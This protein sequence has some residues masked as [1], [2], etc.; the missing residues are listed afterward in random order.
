MNAFQQAIALLDGPTR[1]RLPILMASFALVALLEVFSIGLIFPLMIAL[2]NP[3]GLTD[4]PIFGWLDVYM[5]QF[6]RA[7]LIIWLGL[8][9][10]AG[11]VIKN[12]LAVL[13]VRWQYR[14]I[15]NAEA[16]AG[17]RLYARYLTAPWPVVAGRNTSELIRNASNSVSHAFLSVIIPGIT[18][19]SELT[20]AIL[21]IAMLLAL[22]P[23]IAAA[24]LAF[25]L[26][27]GSVYYLG[28][29]NRL[30]QIGHEFQ[31]ANFGLLNHLKQGLGA[32][33]EIRVLSRSDEFL[34]QLHDVRRAYAQSQARRSFLQVLP[35]YYFETMLVFA[36][37]AIVAAMTLTRGAEA[38]PPILA[39]FA[40]ATLRLLASAGRILTLIQQ[41]RIGL[42]PLAAISHDMQHLRPAD[43]RASTPVGGRTDRS[44]GAPGGIVLT[45]VTFS[46]GSDRPA[47]ADLS[48]TI[49]WGESLGILGPSG[50]GKSTLI[51][52]ILGLIVPDAGRIEID[53]HDMTS[54]LPSWQRRVGYVPQ[55][56]YLTDDT[57]RR[58]VAFGLADDVIDND[59]LRRALR[60]ANLD[61]FV[62]SLPRG[63]DTPV[64]E[65][66]AFL[67][68]GQRQRIGIAR[69]LYHD[70]SVLVLDEATSALDSETEAVVLSAVEALAGQKTVI[71]VA[72]RL[73]TV[74]RCD[75]LLM[76][77]QGKVADIGGFEELMQRNETFVRMIDLNRLTPDAIEAAEL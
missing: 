54:I 53:S 18:L 70:P 38:V 73:S 39:L 61:G 22:D 34:R 74:R 10:G 55:T 36:V 30:A 50:S 7:Q 11:F 17:E 72:H 24:T 28:V 4:M 59:A 37:I 8:L 65:L 25:S 63:A 12:A 31:D 9:I 13:L 32:G 77:S 51:D 46:Y 27:A 15:F 75:R 23:A 48:L 33:R 20:L 49:H 76:L 35:R 2:V 19:A 47:I 6:D 43:P 40:V 58:N 26:A 69:A 16:S 64:G 3:S 56:I 62:A 14:I 21:V 1:R 44:H 5:A 60:Q 71:V 67:S 52:L 66:G 68:G 57:L 42:A 29:R 45:N 41:I